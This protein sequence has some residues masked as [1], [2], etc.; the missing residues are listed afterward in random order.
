MPL[1][2]AWRHGIHNRGPSTMSFQMKQDILNLFKV[3]VWSRIPLWEPFFYLMAGQILANIDQPLYSYFT[4][5]P[6]HT[7]SIRSTTLQPGKHNRAVI[8]KHILCA[9]V[10]DLMSC[11]KSAHRHKLFVPQNHDATTQAELYRIP[12]PYIQ[13]PTNPSISAKPLKKSLDLIKKPKNIR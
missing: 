7:C 8:L 13:H 2:I 10:I 3:L 12:N 1:E 5:M 11:I 6:K 9:S 4:P